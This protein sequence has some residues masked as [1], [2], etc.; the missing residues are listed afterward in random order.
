MMDVT[1]EVM[2]KASQKKVRRPVA[3]ADVKNS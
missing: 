1:S 2:M 3:G